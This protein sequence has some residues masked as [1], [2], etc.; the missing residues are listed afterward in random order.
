[1]TLTVRFTTVSPT[2]AGTSISSSRFQVRGPFGRKRE[3]ESPTEAN[4]RSAIAV[5]ELR[6]MILPI[7]RLRT[8]NSDGF[9]FDFRF[10][11]KQTL[12]F[13]QHHRGKVYPEMDAT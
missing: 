10:V 2:G 6:C 11:F 7:E 4:K 1:M 9:N 13:N 5:V 8:E 3:H 12:H